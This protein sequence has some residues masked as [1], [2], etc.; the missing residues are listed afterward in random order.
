MYEGV[1]LLFEGEYKD[2]LPVSVH[3]VLTYLIT[4]L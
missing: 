2:E 3:S 1:G 4:S